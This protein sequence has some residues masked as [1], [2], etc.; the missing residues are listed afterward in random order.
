M[1]LPYVFHVSAKTHTRSAC[2]HMLHLYR[3]VHTFIAAFISLL[4]SMAVTTTTT[5]GKQF[6]LDLIFE[7]YTRYRS[8]GICECA[9]TYTRR[10]FDV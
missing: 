1:Q 7:F 5:A 3:Y 2:V 8:G 10:V 4:H 9:H 6:H